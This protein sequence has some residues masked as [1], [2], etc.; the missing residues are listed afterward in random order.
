MNPSVER[1]I[2]CE[3]LTEDAEEVTRKRNATY[4]K[5]GYSFFGGSDVHGN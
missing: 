2:D 1:G 4:L 3:G 5:F